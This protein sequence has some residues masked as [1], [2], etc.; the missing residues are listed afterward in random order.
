M[1][2]AYFQSFNPIMIVTLAPVF[3]AIWSFLG[4]RGIEPSSP[5][6]QAI[7]LLLL[8]LGYLFIAFGVKDV[9]PGVK[10]SMIWLTGC[11]SST[12]WENFVWLLSDCRWYTN[13]LRYASPRC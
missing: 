4:K 8:S 10:V 1:P 7:G 9:E 11:I 3:A 13:S 6:K 5:R 12:P 2:A